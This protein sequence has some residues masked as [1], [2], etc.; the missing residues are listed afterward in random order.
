[1]EAYIG[2]DMGKLC[3]ILCSDRLIMMNH[4][5]QQLEYVEERHDDG[6]LEQRSTEQRYYLLFR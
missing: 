6:E 3:F 1:M 4:D 2:T 5:T